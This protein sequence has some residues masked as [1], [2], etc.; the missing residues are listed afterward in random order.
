VTVNHHVTRRGWILFA[1]MGVIW[2]IPYLLIKVAV[3]ELSPAS[4]V[5]LR[6]A[7]AAVILLPLAAARGNLRPLLPHWRALLMYTG[8]EIAIPWFLLSE[9]EIHLS[10][11]LT[12]LLVATVPLIGALLARATGA[13]DRMAPR[14]VAGLMVGFAGVAALVGLD[15]SRSDLGAFGEM[16]VITVCYAVGPMII[17]RKLAAVPAAGVVAVSLVVTAAVYAPIGILQLPGSL[18]SANVI[19]AV[20]TLAIVCTALAFLVFFALIAEVGPVRAT[21]ITY[22]NPAVALLLGVLLLHERLT[23]GAGAGFV[24]ILLGS[25]LATRR[26]APRTTVRSHDTVWASS[27]T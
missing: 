23:M 10:S 8:I 14:A 3:G 12:G 1:A 15:F 9:A 22:V 11:S 27:E 25:F 18:V 26:A 16:A 13:A 2:G 4:L 19:A 6:T 24:L 7:T 17:A 21:I 20:A 5:F